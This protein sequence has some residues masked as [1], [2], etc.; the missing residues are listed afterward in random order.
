VPDLDRN[1][2]TWRNLLA[3]GISGGL[4]PCPS[5]LV[6]MLGAIAL[7][8]V[9]FGLL[10]IVAFSLGLSSVLTGIGIALV[11]TGKLL[12]RLP[13]SGRLVRVLPVASALFITLLGA[14][15]TLQAWWQIWPM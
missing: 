11:S 7:Q 12:E 5:A 3:L 9:G 1:A 15:I 4:L 13:E 2:V 6:V 14:G 8:R 10:L